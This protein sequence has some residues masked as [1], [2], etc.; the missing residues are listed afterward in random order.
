MLLEPRTRKRKIT[1]EVSEAQ[2]AGREHA[3]LGAHAPRRKISIEVSEAQRAGREHAVLGAHAP[4]RRGYEG[5]RQ[6]RC[7]KMDWKTVVK[8]AEKVVFFENGG[9]HKKLTIFHKKKWKNT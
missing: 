5:I 3:G 9:K 1:I 4:R 7:G 6:G 2:R 8:V